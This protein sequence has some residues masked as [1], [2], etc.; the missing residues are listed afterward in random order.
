KQI[1]AYDNTLIVF[2]SDHGDMQ[3]DHWMLSKSCYFD[4][5]FHVPM[6][7]RDPTT[8]ADRSRGTQVEAFTESVDIMPTI[9]DWIDRDIP[10]Q[11]NGYSL[12][13]FCRGQQPENWRQEYHA[14]FDL[15][16]P[17]G[18]A[19]TPPLGL[20]KMKCM[21]SIAR[22]E[23]YKYVHF[24]GLPPLF[25]DLKEDPDEFIDR[26]T[27]PDYQ[28]RVLE[29]TGKMLTWRMEYADSALTDIRLGDNTD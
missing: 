16:S 26:S 19:K 6:I 17:G 18:Y 20:A 7:V 1:G 24:A 22:G 14:E 12:L 3:G 13:P 2:T 5:A 21:V 15:R 8:A 28:G 27:D 9:L 25:F 23:R 11:C 29:Y 10:S 4:Q